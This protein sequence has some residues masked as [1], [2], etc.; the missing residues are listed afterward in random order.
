MQGVVLP[1][2]VLR[3]SGDSSNRS[4][5]SGGIPQ[6][7]SAYN[8]KDSGLYVDLGPENRLLSLS[9]AA[10]GEMIRTPAVRVK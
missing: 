1:S 7:A 5:S 4:D 6:R 8:N 2:A 9:R 3:S 10:H